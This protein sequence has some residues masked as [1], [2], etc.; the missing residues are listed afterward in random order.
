MSKVVPLFK[1]STSSG[2]NKPLKDMEPSFIVNGI[3]K[4][5]GSDGEATYNESW[6]K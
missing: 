2:K 4:Y 1:L 3:F 6:S 5:V